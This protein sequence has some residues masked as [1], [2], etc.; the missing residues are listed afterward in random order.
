MQQQMRTLA[1][2]L[3]VTPVELLLTQLTFRH[4]VRKREKDLLPFN[5]HLPHTVQEGFLFFLVDDQ[6]G[7]L[8]HCVC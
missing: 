6:A 3:W 5:C 8:P 1:K 4:A 2:F 7:L